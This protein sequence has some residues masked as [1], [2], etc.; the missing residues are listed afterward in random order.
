MDCGPGEPGCAVE[1]ILASGRRGTGSA[2]AGSSIGM[3]R[4]RGVVTVGAIRCL[5]GPFGGMEELTRRS[6]GAPR[7]VAAHPRHQADLDGPD[8]VGTGLQRGIDRVGAIVAMGTKDRQQE[9]ADVPSVSVAV[10][11]FL[12]ATLRGREVLLGGHLVRMRSTRR[13]CN[14]ARAQ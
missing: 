9:T 11:G 6:H 1:A 2:R 12:A 10:P 13:I 8:A 5:L 14:H 7:M 4:G 3:T